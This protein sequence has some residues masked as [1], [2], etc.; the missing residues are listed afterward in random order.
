MRP[1]SLLALLSNFI[2][3]ASV[4]LSQTNDPQDSILDL[5]TKGSSVRG[6][7]VNNGMPTATPAAVPRYSFNILLAAIM[8]FPEL[9]Q[10]LL[11]SHCGLTLFAP[12]DQA[13]FNL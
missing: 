9:E 5:L 10:L 2:V 6:F 8:R 3:M 4:V 1:S 7:A 12:T 13:L 11:S